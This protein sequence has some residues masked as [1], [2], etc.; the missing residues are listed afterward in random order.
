LY[1]C[2]DFDAR[3]W[4]RR[5]ELV[6][7]R[8]RK[9]VSARQSA[10]FCRAPSP[11]PVAI[12]PRSASALLPSSHTH[13]PPFFI[14]SSPIHRHISHRDCESCDP[15]HIHSLASRN[16]A[17]PVLTLEPNF[18]ENH[19]LRRRLRRWWIR[20][21]LRRW[22]WRRRRRIRRRV[23][24]PWRPRIRLSELLFRWVC[25]KVYSHWQLRVYPAFFILTEHSC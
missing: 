18:P 16:H 10:I 17:R 12:Y 20:R 13:A 4:R 15:H 3:R 21:R 11:L 24:Y 19:V 8:T 9:R 1:L 14:T 22:P 7:I 25:P 5:A 23:R 6:P 2:L